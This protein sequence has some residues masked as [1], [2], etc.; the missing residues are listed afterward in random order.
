MTPDQPDK[1]GQADA[2]ANSASAAPTALETSPPLAPDEN[3]NI[4]FA[5]NPKTRAVRM[6]F[7][8]G[9]GTAGGFLF[10][11]FHFPLPWMLGPLVA[12]TAASLLKFP[13]ARPGRLRPM[14]VPVLGVMLGAGFTP[15]AVSRFHLWLFSLSTLLIYAAVATAAT[16]YYLARRSRWDAPTAY[17]AASP[18][19]FG[20]MVLLGEAMGADERRVSLIHSV[21]IMLTVLIIPFWFK[22]HEGYQPGNMTALGDIGDLTLKDGALLIACAVAGYYLASKLRLPAAQ[23]LGPIVLSALVHLGGLTK[24]QPPQEVVALAQIVIGASIG[25][26][27][28]GVKL[29]EV[30]GIIIQAVGITV[31]MLGSAVGFAWGVSA[32]TGLPVETVCLA[33]APGGLAEMS[34]IALSLGGDVAFVATHHMVRVSFLVSMAPFAFRLL[35]NVLDRLDAKA[36]G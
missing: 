30:F 4:T 20:A 6:V 26:R 14:V 10:H 23:L 36:A 25:C 17:F 22:F 32:V 3:V 16:A 33:F 21:R 15:D 35:R 28:L 5:G 7:S 27:F 2:P 29:G 13:L 8:L 31:L 12:T 18:G 34:L 11:H 9:L 19:G 1:A 24:A